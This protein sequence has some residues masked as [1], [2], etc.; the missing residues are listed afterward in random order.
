M[1]K[2]KWAEHHLIIQFLKVVFKL[3]PL[4]GGFPPNLLVL[5]HFLLKQPFAL[6]EQCSLW[7]ITFTLS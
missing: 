7:N 4:G 5:L 1:T 3:C 2:I 6:M